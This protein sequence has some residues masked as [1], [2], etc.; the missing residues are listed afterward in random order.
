M[1][2]NHGINLAA[3]VAWNLILERGVHRRRL[4]RSLYGHVSEVKSARRLYRAASER[5]EQRKAG[6]HG[7]VAVGS[8]VQ[9]ST[10][11]PL[12]SRHPQHRAVRLVTGLEECWLAGPG[13]GYTLSH[14]AAGSGF[15]E[16]R[17]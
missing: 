11:L 4:C 5:V 13:D 15:V 7:Q 9:R 17:R 2:P 16:A 6:S 8:H 14:I 1:Q 10:D 3:A 12:L